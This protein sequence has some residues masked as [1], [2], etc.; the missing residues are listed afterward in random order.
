MKSKNIIKSIKSPMNI[1]FRT[2]PTPIG[3]PKNISIKTIIT[4]KLI[5]ACPIVIPVTLDTP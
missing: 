5:L 1:K 3:C 2:V 4:P